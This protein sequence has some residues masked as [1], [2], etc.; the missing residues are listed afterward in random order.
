LNL[1]PV[2]S[3]VMASAH[4]GAASPAVHK[5]PISVPWVVLCAVLMG[6]GIW[7]MT[8]WLYTFSWIWF[9]GVVPCTIGVL[10]LLS[11]RAGWDRAG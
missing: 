8:Y 6:A 4:A 3:F 1:S 7:S 11:P 9:L 10:M 2:A 5:S